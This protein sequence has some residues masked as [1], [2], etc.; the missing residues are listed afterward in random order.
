MTR[1][2]KYYE[3]IVCPDLLLKLPI[4]NIISYHVL[5]SSYYTRARRILSG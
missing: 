2:S 5:I 1:F 4:T 3:R